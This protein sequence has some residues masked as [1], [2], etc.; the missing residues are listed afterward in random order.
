M[1]DEKNPLLALGKNLHPMVQMV[2]IQSGLFVS[3]GEIEWIDFV[4]YCGE[5][6]FIPEGEDREPRKF[7]LF[8][9]QVE[10]I[11]IFQ[12]NLATQKVEIIKKRDGFL[13]DVFGMEPPISQTT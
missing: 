2:Q 6:E 5:E 9:I 11:K 7:P 3:Q 8:V 13:L 1:S 10:P 12:E 4:A